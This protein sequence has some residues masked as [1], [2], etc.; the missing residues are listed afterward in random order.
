M[1]SIC[2]LTMLCACRKNGSTIKR[3]KDSDMVMESVQLKSKDANTGTLD[4]AVRIIPD[5]KLLADKDRSFKSSLWYSMDSCFYLMD[6]QRKIYSAIVQPIANGVAGTFEYMLSF[7][8]DDLKTGNWNLIYDD[9]Y[10]NHKK[11]TLNLH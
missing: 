4:Y 6:G 1:L 2:L 11:Y 8:E 9:R 5:K 10:L 3:V 7:N